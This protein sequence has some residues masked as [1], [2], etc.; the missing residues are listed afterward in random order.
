MRR[1]ANDV[2]AVQRMGSR[3]LRQAT[4]RTRWVSVVA[5]SMRRLVPAGPPRGA[6]NPVALMRPC[7]CSQAFPSG[8]YL[9]RAS[10]LE[11]YAPLPMLSMKR[12]CS[13]APGRGRH[14]YERPVWRILG[15][16]VSFRD[17]PRGVHSGTEADVHGMAHADVI[18]EN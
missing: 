7:P 18:I 3:M 15:G 17:E 5:R 16:R 14:H 12:T 1:L 10:W 9:Q 13:S 2:R 4:I 11:A 8:I 6:G